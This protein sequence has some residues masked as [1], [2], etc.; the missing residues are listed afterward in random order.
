VAFDVP[1]NAVPL[2]TS[3]P[4]DNHADATREHSRVA[5]VTCAELPDLDADDR[6]LLEPLRRLGIHAEPAVWDD[7]D[8]DWSGYD[9]AVLRSTWDYPT[10][11]GEF[12]DWAHRVPRLANPAAVVAW[13][14]D[15]RYLADLAAAG[16]PVVATTW[17]EPG[18]PWSP[19][20]SGEVVIKPAVGA[21]SLDAGRYDLT[22]PDHH[23]L[24]G[25]LVTRLHAAGRVAMVQ[26]YLSAVDAYGETALLFLGGAYS[27][28]VRKGPLLTGP[29]EAI[30]GLYK[31]EDISPRV[32]SAAE[33]AVAERALAV[34]PGPLLYARV[35]LIPAADGEPVV[36]ELE[37]AEPSL[38]LG[39]A[40]GAVDR[41]ATAIAAEISGHAAH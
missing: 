14:T 32:P 21:G 6:L 11:R 22:D 15:K 10:R 25:E 20:R 35:D 36:V 24:A 27:H 38:F 41:F 23:R 5:L 34:A 28:A 37:L 3:L 2:T 12:V 8:V 4:S 26:P 39:Y 40:D 7:P 19:P 16:T 31:V 1:P 9:L 17:L 29:Q 18:R 33:R 30:D 13:N